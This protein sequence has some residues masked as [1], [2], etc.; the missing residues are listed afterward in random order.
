MRAIDGRTGEWRELTPEDVREAVCN[1]TIRVSSLYG[2]ARI[3]FGIL[4]IGDAATRGLHVPP[5][6]PPQWGCDYCGTLMT[7]RERIDPIPQKCNGCRAP[8]RMK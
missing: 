1:D 8:R 7:W 2:Y 5:L 6:A 3:D 4:G